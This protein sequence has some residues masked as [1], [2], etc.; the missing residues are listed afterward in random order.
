MLQFW[1]YLYPKYM[2]IWIWIYLCTIFIVIAL[3]GMKAFLVNFMVGSGFLL[4][5]SFQRFLSE[6]PG[7]LHEVLVCGR[8]LHRE[9]GWRSLYFVLS[10]FIYL[11]IIC[12][13]IACLCVCFLITL[14]EELFGLVPWGGG[15]KLFLCFGG[16]ALA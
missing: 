15:G 4:A 10:L 14:R 1:I 11:L 12:L 2:D 3:R 8:S 7:E 6:K 16:L 13:F 5:D 9:I